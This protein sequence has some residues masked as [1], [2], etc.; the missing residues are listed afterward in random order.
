MLFSFAPSNADSRLYV[1]LNLAS[2]KLT[3]SSMVFACRVLLVI[4]ECPPF[5]SLLFAHHSLRLTPNSSV[6]I[7][8]RKGTLTKNLGVAERVRINMAEWRHEVS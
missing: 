4:F 8:C 2:S 3:R 5:V 7:N 6:P 1:F